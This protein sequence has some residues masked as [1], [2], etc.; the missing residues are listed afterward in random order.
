MGT[1]SI[2]RQ[3]IRKSE[4]LF[5][6]SSKKESISQRTSQFLTLIGEAE[7]AKV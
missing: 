5:E 7:K 3:E 6:D 1:I 4:E 2:T